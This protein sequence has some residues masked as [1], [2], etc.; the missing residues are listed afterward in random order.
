MK[1]CLA[2]FLACMAC[3]ALQAQSRYDVVIDEIMSDPTPQVG[4]PNSEWIEIRNT[5]N[6]T[7]NLAGWR[8]G[9][10]S[11][12]SGPMP[13]YN[14]LPDSVVVVTTASAVAALQAFGAVISVTSFPSLDNGGELLFLRAANGRTIHAVEYNVAWFDNAVKSD[15]GWTLEMVDTK[16]PCSGASNWKASVNATGGTPGKKNS[17]DAANNDTQAPALI[18]GYATDSV[19]ITLVFDEPLDSLVATAISNYVLSPGNTIQS[20]VANAPLY[21]RVS[22]RLANPLQRNTVYTIT[23]SNVTDCKG[24]RVAAFNNCKIGL[25]SQ[26]DSLD[27]VVNEILFNPKSDAVDYVE[28]YNRSNKIIDLKNVFLANRTTAGGIATPRALN[29][30]NYLLFPQEFIVVTENAAIVKRFYVAKNPNAFTEISMP[31][32]NDDKGNVVVLNN[33]GKIVDELSYSEKWHFALIDN[34]EG[35]ALERIDYSQPTNKADNWTSAAKTVEFGTPTY[36]NSQFR[37]DLQAQGEIAV[38]PKVF[39]PNNDGVDDFALLNYQ[40]PAPNYVA[41]I[42]I[43][44]AGGRPVRVLARNATCAQKGSFRWDGLDD[45]NLRVKMGTYIVFTEIF[46]LQGKKNSFKNTVVVAERL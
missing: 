44:D 23:A 30:D 5:T 28:L 18:R 20:V 15:G 11:G 12:V 3:L 4:L 42:T 33:I 34:N 38:S 13:T 21:N 35:V 32:F 25:A 6:A 9:D 31:S 24:N 7:I 10:G 37:A 17:V 14:L 1:K 8:V 36:Q 22:M 26:A 40:F 29:A 19:N 2:L 46:N 16:N 39:S 41:N 43:Y 45:K 27:L